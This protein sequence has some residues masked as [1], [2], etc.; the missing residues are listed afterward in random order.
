MSKRVLIIAYQFPP[1]GGAG[2]QRVSKFVKYLSSYG[3]QPT[4]LTVANPSVPVFDDSLH[5]ECLANADIRKARTLEPGYKTKTAVAASDAGSTSWFR[6]M[7]KNA[8]RTVAN[9]V[10]QPDPQILW[11]PFA[12]REGRNVLAEGGFDAIVATGPPFSSFLVARKLSRETGVPY[13][14]DYRDEWDISNAMWENKSQGH[15]SLAIQQWQQRLA[16]RDASVV[17]ATTQASSN[18]LA[19]RCQ[20]ARSHARNEVLFNGFDPDDIQAAISASRQ[21]EDEPRATVDQT[22]RY[23]MAYVGTLWNLT[24]V[25]PLVDAIVSLAKRDPES[26]SFLELVFAGR[27]TE[28]QDAILN[29]LEETPIKLDRRAYLDHTAAVQLMHSSDALF[30]SLTDVPSATRVI[31]AKMFEY[32]ASRKRVLGVMP[33]GDAWELLVEY[34]GSVLHVPGDVFGIRDSLL[35]ELDYFREFGSQEFDYVNLRRFSRQA[36]TGELAEILNSLCDEKVEQMEQA[37]LGESA[38][39]SRSASASPVV[40]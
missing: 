34:P 2:V 12:V 17:L 39:E 24:S 16:L 26:L 6:G 40:E 25:E 22:R 20:E 27:R 32:M 10:L 7:I 37:M 36:L 11:Y 33:Q 15:L 14:L 28:A 1:V 4:V 19:H 31:P 30:L 5:A 18:S 21:S 29:R 23:R 13:V 38:K 35:T 8:V 9:F 3:W